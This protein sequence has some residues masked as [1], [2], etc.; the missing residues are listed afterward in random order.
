MSLEGG[1][2]FGVGLMRHWCGNKQKTIDGN[3]LDS[4]QVFVSVEGGKSFVVYNRKE[5]RVANDQIVDV[6]VNTLR[7]V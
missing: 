5:A 4:L 3:T 1:N 7:K 2:S 6:I